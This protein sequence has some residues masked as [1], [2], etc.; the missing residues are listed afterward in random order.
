[1]MDVSP[2]RRWLRLRVWLLVACTTG[3]AGLSGCGADEAPPPEPLRP[4]RYEFARA[5]G[6]AQTRTFA[7]VAQASSEAQVSFRV[8][9]VVEAVNTRVGERVARGTVL[10]RVDASDYVIQQRQAEAAQAQA[11][12]QL[13]NAEATY[14]R[15]LQLYADQGAS[16]SDLDAA[17]AQYESA[18]AH[19]RSADAQQQVAARQVGYTRLTAP[20]TGAVADVLVAVGEQV[21]PGRPAFVVSGGG[22][23]DVEVA[24]PEGLI[25]RIRAGT[26]ARVR[27]GSLGGQIYAAT[28]AEVGIAST[29]STTT[30]PVTVRL[31][32]DADEVRPGMA[33]DVTLRLVGGTTSSGGV[34]VPAEAV[35]EDRAGR[36]VFVL[37]PQGDGEALALR[38]QVDLGGLTDDGI[39]ITSGVGDGD[40]V[41]TAGLSAL[42]DSQRVAL[43]DAPASPPSR[44]D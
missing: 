21:G 25:G 9:G 17:R 4:V 26:P 30:F 36:Y 39:T 19:V 7:G 32:S 13:R 11:T 31:A 28:V 12:A 16:Q 44:T 1:M 29:A 41:V 20:L 8:G 24:V 33:A 43:L 2:F 42:A 10:A 14:E 38:R 22:P 6:D 3:L 18:Q 40:R 35:G 34:V 27:F 15:T 23:L 5:S 37:A